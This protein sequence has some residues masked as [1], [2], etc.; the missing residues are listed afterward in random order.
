MRPLPRWMLWALV[1][2]AIVLALDFV[3]FGIGATMANARTP[4]E[5]GTLGMALLAGYLALG[6]TATAVCWWQG[7]GI[8]PGL[9]TVGTIAFLLL[10]GLV[11]AFMSLMTVLGMNR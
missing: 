8:D 5:A 3:A 6:L 7:R 10:Q 4:R 2:L 9:R 11:F 1:L